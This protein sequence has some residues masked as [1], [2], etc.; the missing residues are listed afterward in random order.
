MASRTRNLY[1]VVINFVL[2]PIVLILFPYLVKSF[3]P[4]SF[5]QLADDVAIV[6][7]AGLLNHYLWHVKIQLFNRQRLGMQLL[8]CLPAILFLL[9]SRLPVWLSVSWQRLNIRILLTVIFVALAEEL[10]F[11]G[12]L[13]PL[14]LSVTHQHDFLAVVISSIG[15]GFAHIVNIA[16]MPITVVLL[17]IILVVATGILWGTVYLAT[18]NLSLTILLHI[19]D[20]LPLFLTKSAGGLSN[21]SA[22][23]LALAAVIYLGITLLFCGVALLQLHWAHLAEARY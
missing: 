8:Q 18:H 6:V 12:L 15:F 13:L 9:F 7:I 10:V 21:V 3:I 5:G 4:E 19:L 17:Q 2:V 22:N 1:G 14:S 16:H 23:Q 11:R 20:D